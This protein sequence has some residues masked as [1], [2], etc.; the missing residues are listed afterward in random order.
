MGRL[1]CEHTKRRIQSLDG[2]WRFVTD[3]D[4]VGVELGYANG[5][6][7]SSHMTVPS[8]WN[9]ALGLLKYEG[10]VWYEKKFYT[11]G[12]VLR[13]CFDAVMTEAV[14]YLDGEIIGSHYG[15][16]SQFD[17]LV[18]GVSAGEHRLTVRVDNSFDEGSIPQ[19]YVDWYHYGGITRGVRVETLTGVCVLNNRLEYTLSED[20]K[21]AVCRPVAELYNAERRVRC[22]RVTVSIGEEL[23]SCAEIEVRGERR[24]TAEL[25]EF[26]L[27]NVELWNVGA[28]VLYTVK[29]ETET[30]D[31]FDRVGFRKVEV[32][33]KRLYINGEETEI[34]GINRHDEHPDFGFAFPESLMKRDID[35]ICELGCNAIRGSHYPNSQYFVDL[36]DELGLMFW[37]EIPIWGCGFPN[38][39]LGSSKVISRG[40]E[41][42]RE[43]V[44]YYYNHPSIILWGMHNEI[45]SYSKE[46]YK[47][48]KLY[49]EFLK[50]NGGNRAVVYASAHPER[51]ICFEFCDIIALNKYIGWYDR[52][53]LNWESYLA[54]IKARVDSLGFG[55]KP[56]VI[57][58]FGGA[59][60]FGFHDDKETVW[61]EEYQAKIL[62]EAL[63]VFR[64]DES[65]IGYYVWQFCDMRTNIEL[66]LNR[67]RSF[68]NKGIMNEYRK[69]KLAYYALQKMYTV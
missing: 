45:N 60:I 30:D 25:P 37:S 57:G 29:Y 46:A 1:F 14:V 6:S 20:M 40:L 18:R 69:P 7:D 65:V 68:N 61:C 9:T 3:K 51:D 19:S 39:I 23:L 35:L 21:C 13:F 64:K 66:S 33:N 28:P 24:V 36:L 55:D 59:A 43:M 16:F 58:E 8:V 32:E 2:A 12:G 5:L 26:R 53:N 63:E 56:L 38:K 27:E 54:E 4:N 49:Y 47:M 41:M 62:T 15:G 34:R 31:L 11:D 42:H 17:I 10:V 67:A 44:K 50:A 22:A 48:S 52:G